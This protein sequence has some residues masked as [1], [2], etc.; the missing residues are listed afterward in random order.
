M[1]WN[2]DGRSFGGVDSDG[3]CIIATSATSTAAASQL[4]RRQLRRPMHCN[5]DGR[6]SGGVDSVGRYI[7]AA[8]ATST[9]AASLFRR[10]QL[11]R[12][13]HC[14]SDGRS[15]GGVDSVGRCIIAAPATSTAAASQLRRR[16]LRRPMHCGS[17]DRQC[18]GHCVLRHLHGS[19]G[20]VDSGRCRSWW[21]ARVGAA[22]VV[23]V[24]HEREDVR[25]V[26]VRFAGHQAIGYDICSRSNG[27]QAGL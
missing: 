7:I 4:R 23:R 26:K 11:R 8:P 16:Q 18:R 2:S 27:Y 10:R 12:P 3:R 15:S 24:L 22:W 5:S 19:S 14:N 13:M 6:S 21:S 17:S 1:H 25:C 20:D 9:A